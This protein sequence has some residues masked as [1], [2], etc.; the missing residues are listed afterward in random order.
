MARQENYKILIGTN[1]A[2]TVAGVAGLNNG[3]IAMVKD[4]MTLLLPGETVANSEYIY[5]VQGT[6]AGNAPK[7]SAKIQG[8]Q[9]T[10]WDGSQ[11]AAEVQQTAV[12]GAVGGGVGSIN[13]VNDTE[14]VL[15]IILTYDKVIGS[16]RQLVRRYNFQS[17]AA[18]TEQEIAQ[19]IGALVQ[20]DLYLQGTGGTRIIAQA[21][22]AGA[23]PTNWGLTLTGV[24]QTPL[25]NVIDGHEQVSFKVALDGGFIAGGGATTLAQ[26]SPP[27]M[28]YGSGTGVQISDLERAA[29][30]YEGVTNLMR[31]PIPNMPVYA[32]LAATYDVYSITHSDR[33][34]TANLNKD[35]LSPE[36]TIV[37][38]PDGA[39]DQG[40]FEAEI[41]PWM[42]SLAGNF[43]A[44][45]L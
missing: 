11:Y 26:N 33:H 22:A 2:R 24:L 15:T 8:L 16:E 36:M 3:E 17:S 43:P 44:V 32:V 20:A 40:N 31:F 5:V 6:G 9:V 38:I 35:G 39:A 42:N 1:V 12:V 10:K 45:V 27:Q 13:V 25:Y 41:N 18:A 19:G 30:G 37:A 7:F 28:N 34:A 14:Y 21:S 23:G 4:D 29:Q